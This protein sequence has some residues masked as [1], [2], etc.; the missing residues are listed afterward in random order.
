MPLIHL[1]TVILNTIL[2]LI[3]IDRFKKIVEKLYCE[4]YY[5]QNYTYSK[6]DFDLRNSWPVYN[7]EDVDKLLIEH[8]VK[9]IDELVDSKVL[10]PFFHMEGC[11]ENPLAIAPYIFDSYVDYDMELTSSYQ[12]QNDAEELGKKSKLAQILD[13]EFLKDLSYGMHHTI[14][15]GIGLDRLVKS[16][17]D[18]KSLR[19]VQVFPHI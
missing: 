3:P 14:G 18:K 13:A 17:L 16:I 19:D 2:L 10:G 1:N 5:C 15:L 7:K 8:N 11:E 4:L 6:H 12:E 9:T